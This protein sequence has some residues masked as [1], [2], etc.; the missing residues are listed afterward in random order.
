MLNE[1]K[2][3]K[4]GSDYIKKTVADQ[5]ASIESNLHDYVANRVSY[6][7]STIYGKLDT[8]QVDINAIK[9]DNGKYHLEAMKAVKSLKIEVEKFS[10]IKPTT[11]GQASRIA[12]ITPCD[13]SVL[14][15]YLEK[16]KRIK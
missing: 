8:F 15:V 4:L 6:N 3:I 7:F 1:I 10:K 12:G 5:K 11:I 14:S 16:L 13:L 2:Y 9:I